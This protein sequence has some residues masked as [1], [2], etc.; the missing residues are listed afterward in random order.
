MI[1][2]KFVGINQD[3]T[4]YLSAVYAECGRTERRIFGW[5]YLLLEVSVMGLGSY[6]RILMLLDTQLRGQMEIESQVQFSKWINEM[7]LF[8]PLLFGGSYTWRRGENHMSASRIDRFLFSSQWEELFLQIKQNLL[9]NVG[10]DHRPIMLVC[11]DWK[12]KKSY[13]KFEQWW[14]GVEGFK[15]KVRVWWASFQV[16]GTPAFILATKLKLLKDKLKEWNRENNVSWR[17]KK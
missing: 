11:G 1:T 9:P 16:S 12:I 6:V 14:L 10:S 8:D 3:L 4:W 7:E 2:C 13:F 15:D 17:K 5:N